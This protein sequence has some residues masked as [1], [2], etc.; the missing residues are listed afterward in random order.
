MLLVLDA[1]M[2]A[3]VDAA[4]AKRQMERTVCCG[5]TQETPRSL[6]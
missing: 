6:D 3:G 2:S 1:P 5:V 4:A